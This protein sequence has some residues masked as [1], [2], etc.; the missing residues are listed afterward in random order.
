[1][2]PF[3]PWT[4]LAIFLDVQIYLLW[5]KNNYVSQVG[6]EG[7]LCEEVYPRSVYFL[8][9]FISISKSILIIF[10]I[11]FL[12]ISWL[13]THDFGI[14]FQLC[15]QLRCILALPELLRI[16]RRQVTIIFISKLQYIFEC[17]IVSITVS[18]KTHIKM[19]GN[20]YIW[21]HFLNW[22]TPFKVRKYSL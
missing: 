20:N 16:L 10:Q 21:I 19:A 12:L 7:Q 13:M 3:L 9:M 1:M 14:L 11:L 2:P 6:L 18:N 15:S 5:K 8:N 17:H 4:M 22:N